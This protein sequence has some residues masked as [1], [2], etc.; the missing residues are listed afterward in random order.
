MIVSW[1]NMTYMFSK[2]FLR[3]QKEDII[4]IYHWDSQ[5]KLG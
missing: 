5:I 4:Y 1:D 2:E 3:F